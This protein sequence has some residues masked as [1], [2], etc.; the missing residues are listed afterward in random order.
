MKKWIFLF[1]LIPFI[2]YGQMGISLGGHSHFTTGQTLL[3]ISTN[4]FTSANYTLRTNSISLDWNTGRKFIIGEIWCV[5]G[6]T[7]NTTKKNYDFLTTQTMN[8]EIIERR[9]VPSLSIQYVLAKNNLLRLYSSIG[10]Y[11]IFENLNLDQ[12]NNLDLE[13]SIYKYNSLIPFIRLGIQ[14]NMG[15]FTIN[16]FISYEFQ[17]IYFDRLSDISSETLQRSLENAGVRT[18][19]RFGVLF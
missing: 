19:L 6:L 15:T 10:S 3:P 9:L 2:S 1:I 18:G 13:I 11:G 17:N 7:Y 16:P 14:L 4:E 5:F 12:D 8:Y